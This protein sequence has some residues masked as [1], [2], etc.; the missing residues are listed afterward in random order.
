LLSNGKAGLLDSLV[1]EHQVTLSL[2]ASVG[3]DD[4]AGTGVVVI[5]KLFG[6]MKTAHERVMEQLKKVMDGNFSEAQM[7]DLKREMVM[8]AEQELETISKR[9]QKLVMTY[10]K[11]KT[12]QDVLDKIEHIKRL[13]KADVVA[14]AKKYYGANYITLVKKYGMPDQET[15]K[16]PGYKPIAPKNMDAKSAFARQLEQIPVNQS[17]LRTVDFERDV[18]IRKIND[19]VSLFYKEN[20]INDVFTFTLRYK[21]GSLHTPATDVLG[22]YLSQL[23]TDSLKKQQLEQAWQ[24][25]G[26]TMEIVP[27]DEVFSFNLSGPEA[28]FVPALNLLAHFLRTAKAD[29]KA[30]SDAKDEDKVSRKGFGKQKGDVLRPAIERMLYGQNSAYLT[31]LSKKEIKALRNEELMG[32]FHA[33]QQYDSE[34]FYCGRKSIDEVFT[35]VVS[36]FTEA[37]KLLK[38]FDGDPRVPSKQAAQGLLART[39]LV[40]GDNPLT[41]EQVSAIANTQTDPEF[42]TT[43]S[44]L[45]KAVEYANKVIN[46][47]KLALDPDYIKL[48]GRD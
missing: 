35:Q 27:G 28:Q 14:A 40:W 7:E 15:L 10:S 2:A 8:E 16:Q 19:H 4:A 46:S 41:A 18:D 38:D 13:T 29:D 32:L 23:G 25:I 45:E 22:A 34:L 30:L 33:L 21:E 1:N 9:A 26:T 24:R 6:K 47:G 37:D 17:V 12:W 11:G 36:D 43:P 5:P 39:Y 42:T 20:P 48:W 31:Q 3:F 44:R